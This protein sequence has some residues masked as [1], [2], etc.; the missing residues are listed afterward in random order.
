MADGVRCVAPVGD[1]CGE[2]ATWCAEERALYWCDVNRFLVHRMGPDEAVKTWFFGEPVTALSLTDRPGELIVALGSHIILWRPEDDRRRDFGF[3]LPGAPRARLNDGRAAPNGDF[4][5][6]SMGNNV[7]P[8]GEPTH[9][10]AGLGVLYRFRPGAAPSVEKSDLGIS[11]TLCWSPDRRTFYFGDTMRNLIWAYDYDPDTGAIGAE[12]PFF[13]GFDRGHPDGSATDAQGCL[14]NCRFAGGCVVR[15]TPDG[16]IDRV[17]EVPARNVT[18]CCFG[19]DDLRTLYITTAA[20]RTDES[21]RLAGSLF[22]L[23]T[24]APG[25]DGFRAR[26]S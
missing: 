21:D 19:G 22:A 3:A 9:E 14:W 7:G 15:V 13:Q 1:K 26:L 20:M 18:T 4:W 17:V 23:R 11:N 5:I 12:R 6:G 16:R 10:E 8:D 25:L 2:A 24:D